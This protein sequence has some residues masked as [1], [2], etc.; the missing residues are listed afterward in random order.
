M[1]KK[2]VKQEMCPPDTD[3]PNSK[4]VTTYKHNHVNVPYNWMKP[5]INAQVYT[6]QVVKDCMPKTFSYSCMKVK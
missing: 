6:A 5:R 2:N 1:I 4:F 3:A